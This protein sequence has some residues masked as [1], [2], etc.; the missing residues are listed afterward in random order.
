MARQ[1]VELLRCEGHPDREAPFL[2]EGVAMCADCWRL[3]PHFAKVK[4]DLSNLVN[5]DD[6]A[7]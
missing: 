7:S 5:E 4:I 6:D 2:I 1:H 3:S